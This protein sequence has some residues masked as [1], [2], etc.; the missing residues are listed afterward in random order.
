MKNDDVVTNE[1]PIS[2][3][4]R[5]CSLWLVC[6]YMPA[7][8]SA[9]YYAGL[10]K[11][12]RISWQTLIESRCIIDDV[13]RS[14]VNLQALNHPSTTLILAYNRRFSEKSEIGTAYD[15]DECWTYT[16]IEELAREYFWS[17]V[18]YHV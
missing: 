4:R 15:R 13:K 9:T 11:T 2:H 10:Q 6:S 17:V 7:S 1:E 8:S 14:L 12:N 18:R 3:S 5:H 16:M